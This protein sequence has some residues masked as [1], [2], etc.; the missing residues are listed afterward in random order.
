M[1]ILQ[2]LNDEGLTIILVTHE[3]DIAQFARRVITFRD[4]KIRRDEMVADRPRAAEVLAEMPTVDQ[5]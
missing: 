1:S 5:D 3:P 4:G 2:T